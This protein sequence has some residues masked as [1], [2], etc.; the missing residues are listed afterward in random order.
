MSDNPFEA[1]I[2]KAD[3]EGVKRFQD[4]WDALKLVQQQML[5]G[6]NK[7]SAEHSCGVEFNLDSVESDY[8]KYRFC[9]NL[10]EFTRRIFEII[11]NRDGTFYFTGFWDEGYLRSATYGEKDIYQTLVDYILKGPGKSFWE[12]MVADTKARDAKRYINYEQD[13]ALANTIAETHSAAFG[14]WVTFKSREDIDIF[15]QWL[16]HDTDKDWLVYSSEVDKLVLG[17]L[18]F[19]YYDE[20]Y[21]R[22]EI[23]TKEEVLS[24][25]ARRGDQAKQMLEKV[26]GAE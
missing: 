18:L 1:A 24:T 20:G 25:L 15:R 6:L 21:T 8:V 10:R 4:F 26:K 5:D 23:L 2:P 3:P 9:L 11:L 16:G 13:D 14:Y 12:L 7:I 19:I 22:Y 17:E